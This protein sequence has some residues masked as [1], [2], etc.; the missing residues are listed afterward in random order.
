VKKIIKIG[1]IKTKNPKK[2][3]IYGAYS[4]ITKDD[5]KPANLERRL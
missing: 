4:I 5:R 3:V 2:V 1:H